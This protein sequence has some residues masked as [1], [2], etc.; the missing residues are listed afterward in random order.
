MLFEALIANGISSLEFDKLPTN[1]LREYGILVLGILSFLR[2]LVWVYKA[3][4]REIYVNMCVKFKMTRNPI[5]FYLYFIS[6]CN[7]TQLDCNVM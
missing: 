1:L 3:T 2:V 7:L 6:I 4:C 5:F